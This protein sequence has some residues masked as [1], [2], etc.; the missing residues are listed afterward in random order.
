MMNY[1]LNWNVKVRNKS[2]V[3][4]YSVRRFLTVITLEFRLL[5]LKYLSLIELAK[6]FSIRKRVYKL[7]NG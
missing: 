7:K 2:K 3:I 4:F 1:K 5:G 6:L